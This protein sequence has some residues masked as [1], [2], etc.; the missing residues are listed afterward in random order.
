LNKVLSLR[1]SGQSVVVCGTGFFYAVF[2]EYLLQEVLE[3]LDTSIEEIQWEDATQ[4]SFANGASLIL[5]DVE[6]E[7][8]LEAF[9]KLSDNCDM[10]L[11]LLFEPQLGFLKEQYNTRL[12]P[13][14][15][16]K[17]KCRIQIVRGG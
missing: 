14:I 11:M 2:R 9:V 8:E 6:K 3:R 15:L 4:I 1:E 12:L 16:E 10:D 5:F 17:P 13:I 7:N